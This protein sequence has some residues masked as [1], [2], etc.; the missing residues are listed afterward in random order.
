LPA[1]APL[2]ELALAGEAEA[3]REATRV[4]EEEVKL[5]ARPQLYLVL[6]LPERVIMI[7]G[8]GVELHRLPVL[9]WRASD[10][11]QLGQVFTLHTRPPVSRPK[12]VPG[13]DPSLDPIELRH[14]PVDYDLLF[15]PD[16]LVIV[17]PPPSERPWIWAKSLLRGWWLRGRALGGAGSSTDPAAASFLLRLTLSQDTAQSLAWSVTDGMPMV[18]KRP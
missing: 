17:T 18:I 9:G 7:K 5:A 12:A 8:R 16:L 6:D 1:L 2:V 10:E 13:R 15:E 11:E 14:M 4:L 3:L